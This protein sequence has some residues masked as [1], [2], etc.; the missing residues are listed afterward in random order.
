MNLFLRCTL[1]CTVCSG[2]QL[3]ITLHGMQWCTALCTVCSGVQLC[4]HVRYA[5]VRSSVTMHGMQWC[6][7]LLS[8]TVFYFIYTQLF[9]AMQGM[10]WC[11]AL[12]MQ[13]CTALCY[14]AR[15]AVL[16]SFMLPCK[17]SSVTQLSVTMHG[18]QWCTALCYHARYAVVRSSDTMH[19]M[20]W[21]AA[22]LPCTVCSGAQLSAR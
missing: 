11:T 19:G 5:V 10:K 9:I 12:C 7:T 4:Y 16:H 2:A 1:P 6:A 22:L 13:C 14:H 3:Y 21:C 8:C 15:Y 20:Q 17:I 18:K